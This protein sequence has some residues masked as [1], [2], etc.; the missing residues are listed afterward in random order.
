[1]ATPKA[2]II[3]GAVLPQF[4]NRSAGHVPEQMQLLSLVSFGIA[5]LRQPMGDRGQH[6]AA[7][8]AGNPRTSSARGTHPEGLELALACDLRVAQGWSCAST[9]V[10]G[11]PA[12]P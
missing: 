4:V 6:S 5:D 10:V 7:W 12:P 2:L 11:S 3:F 8:F 9:L 1:M